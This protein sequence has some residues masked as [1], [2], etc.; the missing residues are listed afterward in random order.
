MT[1]DRVAYAPYQE[2]S[3]QFPQVSEAEFQYAVQLFL[4][5][6]RVLSG[7]HA[8]FLAI[9]HTPGQG[10]LL[11]LY[12]NVWGFPVLAQLIYRFVSAHRSSF[13]YPTRLL[14][15][16]LLHPPEYLLVC[17]LFVR[18]LGIIYLIAFASIGTQVIGLIGSE[19][20]LPVGDFLERVQAGIG[21]DGYWRAPTLF[22]ISSS[23]LALMSVVAAGGVLSLSLILGF[24]QRVAVILLFVLYLSLVTAGQVFMAY[25][26]DILLLEV[27]FL[28]IFLSLPGPAVVFLFR[29]LLFRFMFLSGAVKLLSG[30]ATWRNFTALNFHYETQPLP[31]WTSWYMH[32]LPEWFQKGS[33]AM[34]LAIELA[35]P[36]LIFAPR[37]LRLFAAVCLGGLNLLVFLT[38]NFTFFNLLAIA[39][40]LFLLDDADIRRWLPARITKLLTQR[41]VQE[42][43]LFLRNGAL[44]ILAALL[45]FLGVSQMVGTFSGGL[46]PGSKTLV[47]WVAPFHVANSYGLFAVMT[48]TRPE[49][50]IQGSNDGQTWKDYEFKYKPGRLLQ[51]P[52]WVA[53]HQ[54][55]LDWQMWFAALGTYR[56]NPWF[57]NFAERLLLGSE[58]VLKLLDNN[59]FPEEPPRFV[60]AQLYQYRFTDLTTKR[61]NGSWWGREYLGLYLPPAS[62]NVTK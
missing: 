45:L 8:V 2:V 61:T 10:W 56:Q 60:R 34:T 12:Q 15:G 16:Q 33:V 25:Q 37:R 18:L 38:G 4:P 29:C 14:Y 24:L 21:V 35:I 54:P 53:P 36:F 26:W 11:W 23:D 43:R 28:A 55:R 19:G 46:P 27:G 40:C 7:A 13:Y 30:D 59:P 17:R 5:D 3:Q 6:G 50:R 62:L 49:I 44:T 57:I 58:P 22:W 52:R 42:N 20:I 47:R 39:L 51:R 31:T 1:G 41:P 32:Q 48:T 9:S